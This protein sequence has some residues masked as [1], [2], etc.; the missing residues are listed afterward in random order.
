[1]K[2]IPVGKNGLVAMVDD[3]DYDRIS[4]F[5][6]HELP[7]HNNIY[8]ILFVIVPKGQFVDRLMHHK[9]LNIKEKNIRI[10]H[11]DGN[12]LNNQKSNLRYATRSQN[13]MNMDKIK[14][15]GKS[16]SKYKGVWWNR[17]ASKWQAQIRPSKGAIHLGLFNDE[18][19]AARAYDTAARKLYGK[20]ARTN[21]Q[22]D[23]KCP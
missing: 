11:I 9:V 23:N 8:A 12:G 3:E 13:G 17:Q 16:S 4:C 22:E 2:T 7:S 18:E 5:K 15:N 20:F 21:F 10:D 1:M 14:R 19:Q 6:W